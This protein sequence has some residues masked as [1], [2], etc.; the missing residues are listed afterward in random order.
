[1]GTPFEMDQA[2]RNRARPS[3]AK[4]RV[5]IDFLKPQPEFVYVGLIH[6]NSPKTGFMQKLGYEGIPKYCKHC[7]KIGHAIAN[8][9]V[10]ERKRAVKQ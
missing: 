3:M 10:L 8:C 5:E 2:T 4:V 9:K 7:R 6:E 1:M